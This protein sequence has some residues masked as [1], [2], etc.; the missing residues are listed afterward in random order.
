MSTLCD[1]EDAH[2]GVVE[3]LG[4]SICQGC[5]VQV[6]VVLSR[7]TEWINDLND[8]HGSQRNRVG[9]Q[10]NPLLKEMSMITFICPRKKGTQESKNTSYKIIKQHSW[11]SGSTNY[12]ERSRHEIFKQIEHICNELFINE[13]IQNFSKL[14]YITS[15]EI[16]RTRADSRIGAIAA[17]ILIAARQYSVPRSPKEIAKVLSTEPSVVT[18]GTKSMITTLYGHP[19]LESKKE[20]YITT[21]KDFVPRFCC[22]LDFDSTLTKIA[23]RVATITDEKNICISN[24]P[25]AIAG[26]AV[27]IVKEYKIYPNKLL[28]KFK[29]QIAKISGVSLVTL[30]KVRKK[31]HMYRS[32]VFN[33]I[34]SDYLKFNTIT[35]K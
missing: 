21:S 22:K 2:L 32:H 29:D 30:L 10:F 14:L 9:L 23:I 1:C 34:D 8:A 24:T 20:E 35:K 17:S 33:Q 27:L 25:P 31:I 26:G 16:N 5:G 18:K 19:L 12:I 3:H 11:T 15:N 13:E 4:F 6:E 7:D 28:K